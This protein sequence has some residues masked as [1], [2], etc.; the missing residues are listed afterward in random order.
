MPAD[1]ARPFQICG[2]C[3]GA[4]H[5]ADDFVRDPSLRLLGLQF[6]PALPEINLLVFEHA[7]GSSI[8]ILSKR[9]AHLLPPPPSGPLPNL[10]GTEQCRGHCRR[11]ED[12]DACDAPCVNAR[13]RELTRL[14][15]RWNDEARKTAAESR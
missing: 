3:R 4:W 1:G 2:A 9:L 13:D 12:L 6:E 15:K 11:L 10:R 8:S 5:N 7:C 14:V